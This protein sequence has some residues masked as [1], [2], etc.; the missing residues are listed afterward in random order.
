MNA[1]EAYELIADIDLIVQKYGTASSGNY[2]HDGRPGQIGGSAPGY[3]SVPEDERQYME[4][5]LSAADRNDAPGPRSGLPETIADRGSD[6]YDRNTYVN[7]YTKNGYELINTV[8]RDGGNESEIWRDVRFPIERI[9]MAIDKSPPIP[10]GTIMYRGVGSDTGK[11]MAGLDVGDTVTDAAYQ[12]HTLDLYTANKFSGGWHEISDPYERWKAG[13]SDDDVT[14]HTIV[15]AVTKD[16]KGLYVTDRR[17][18]EVI[19]ARGTE[20][21]V[22]GKETITLPEGGINAGSIYHVIT[23]EQV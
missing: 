11:M 6:C 16:T 7:S 12:S 23:V 1:D 14:K 9:D 13:R 4:K 5:T 8:L 2:G 21:K 19:V 10:D 18:N 20:W 3:A 15:R 22:I 17:E